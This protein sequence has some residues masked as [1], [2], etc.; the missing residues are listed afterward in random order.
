[1]K[2]RITE[3]MLVPSYEI[4]KIRNEVAIRLSN[5]AQALEVAAKQQDR[6][7]V[8]ALNALV[9]FVRFDADKRESW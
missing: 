7:S 5:N 8:R 3:T 1:M 9:S 2:R 4:R 6:L